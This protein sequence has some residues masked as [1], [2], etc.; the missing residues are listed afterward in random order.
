MSLV[1]IAGTAE[2]RSKAWAAVVVSDAVP[3]PEPPPKG[4]RYVKLAEQDT[5][6]ADVLHVLVLQP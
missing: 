1:A 5:D 2:A 6:V 3:V 4:R